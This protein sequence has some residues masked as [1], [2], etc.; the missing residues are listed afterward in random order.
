VHLPN[1]VLAI[2]SYNNLSFTFNEQTCDEYEIEINDIVNIPN[3]KNIE[4]IEYSEDTTNN[5]IRLNS[6]EVELPL[7]VRT[8]RNGDKIEVKGML[9]SKKVNNIFTDEKISTKD[10]NLWPIVCDAKDNILWIPGL[11]KSKFDKEKNEEY[12]IILKYN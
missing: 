4:I 8:R 2:K 10:R 3:G 7:Y 1:N 5:T 11:K 12:D 9:G 6:K